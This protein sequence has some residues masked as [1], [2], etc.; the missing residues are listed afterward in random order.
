[1]DYLKIDIEY[2]EWAA[3]E[4]MIQDHAL[5]NVKQLGIEIHDK[6]LSKE[7]TLVADY[8]HYYNLLNTLTERGWRKWKVHRNQRG[9]YNSRLT[10]DRRTCCF[11]LHYVNIKYLNT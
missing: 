8:K 7:N 2:S 10:G 4:S 11:E 3:L 1:M 5:E 9:L 6:L